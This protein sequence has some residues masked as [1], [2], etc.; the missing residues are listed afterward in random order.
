M[1]HK[2]RSLSAVDGTI[3][4]RPKLHVDRFTLDFLVCIINTLDW[5]LMNAHY[6]IKHNGGVRE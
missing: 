3:T 5:C 6:E 1:S 4:V 2:F